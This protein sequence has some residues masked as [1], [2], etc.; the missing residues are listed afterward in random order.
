MPSS[1]ES[2]KMAIDLSAL[3]LATELGRAHAQTLLD[4]AIELC[5][6]DEWAN[7]TRRVTVLHVQEAAS[8]QERDS[9]ESQKRADESRPIRFSR[10]QAG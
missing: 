1:S 4:Q 10:R 6:R 5:N 9:V 2:A 3:R 8:G 7:G